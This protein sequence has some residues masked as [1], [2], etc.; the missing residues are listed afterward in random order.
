MDLSSG[1]QFGGCE[2]FKIFVVGDDVD[3]RSWTFEVVSPYFE[4]FEDCK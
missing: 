2:I 1:E 3:Q 4:S